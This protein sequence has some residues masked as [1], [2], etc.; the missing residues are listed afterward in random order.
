MVR[1]R[2]ATKKTTKKNE[3]KG[4]LEQIQ[5]EHEIETQNDIHDEDEEKDDIVET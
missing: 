1:T 2:K 5:G 4:E 3:K